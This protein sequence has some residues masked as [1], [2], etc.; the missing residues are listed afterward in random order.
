MQSQ[1]LGI[2]ER[3]IGDVCY[4]TVLCYWT[5][6]NKHE[7][8]TKQDQSIFV[9]SQMAVLSDLMVI[10]ETCQHYNTFTSTFVSQSSQGRKTWLA[11]M[12]QLSTHNMKKNIDRCWTTSREPSWCRKFNFNNRLQFD[13][14]PLMLS[15]FSQT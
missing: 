8:N 12:Y 6:I 15:T 4:V 3:V 11:K 7:T 13:N 14:Q 1:T 2:P 10:S 9:F 5:V